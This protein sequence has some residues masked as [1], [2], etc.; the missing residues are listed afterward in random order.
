MSGGNIGW[1][2]EAADSS[3]ID[4]SGGMITDWLYATDRSVV[5]I[6][7]Y[8]FDYDPYGGRWNGGELTGFWMDD[9]PFTIELLDN[10]AVDST[11][12]DHINLVPEPAT[13]SLLLLGGLAGRRRRA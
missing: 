4:I 9:S 6:Y 2:L 8:G 12:Y 5:N 10:V 3:T 7:G 13:L 11:Y 1:Y